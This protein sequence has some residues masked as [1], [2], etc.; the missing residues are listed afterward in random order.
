M[1]GK[2]EKWLKSSGDRPVPRLTF[3]YQSGTDGSLTDFSG[4][5]LFILFSRRCSICR[6]VISRLVPILGQ[7]PA[8]LLILGDQAA[9]DED[10][11]DLERVAPNAKNVVVASAS[12]PEI[13]LGF[14][15]PRGA[16]LK[17]PSL[18][19]LDAAGRVRVATDVP[20]QMKDR[21]WLKQ[22]TTE[23]VPVLTGRE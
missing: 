14:D 12:F 2:W 10:P 5:L 3:H 21:E 8:S 22:A 11:L 4:G 1:T 13:Y 15:I 17:F 20:E 23:C 19:V 9:E 18:F 16:W 6:E 7:L